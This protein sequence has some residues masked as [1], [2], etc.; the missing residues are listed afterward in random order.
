MP[1]GNKNMSLLITLIICSFFLKEKKPCQ[2]I[3]LLFYIHIHPLNLRET[4]CLK[5]TLRSKNSLNHQSIMKLKNNSSRQVII[6]GKKNKVFSDQ[7]DCNSYYKK[8]SHDV[9]RAKY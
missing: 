8:N 9:M 4:L 1:F 2:L 3:K 6:F 5:K 7:I